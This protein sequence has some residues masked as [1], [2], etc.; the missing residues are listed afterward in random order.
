MIEIKKSSQLKQDHAYLL[1]DGFS[2]IYKVHFLEVLPDHGSGEW[3]TNECPSA[4]FVSFEISP[5]SAPNRND[6]LNLCK[7]QGIKVYEAK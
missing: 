3:S 1:D 2:N 4:Q 5:I 7:C 6:L